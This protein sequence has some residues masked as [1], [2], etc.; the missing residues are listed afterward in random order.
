MRN[1]STTEDIYEKGDPPFRTLQCLKQSKQL[2]NAFFDSQLLESVFV[3][4]NLQL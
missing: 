3:H 2:I 1:N 4:Q